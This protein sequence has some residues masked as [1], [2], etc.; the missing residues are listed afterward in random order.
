MISCPNCGRSNPEDARFCLNCGHALVTR[1]GAEERRRVTA[2]FADLV[3]STALSDRHDPEVV[4][5]VVSEFFERATTEIRRYGGTAEQFRGDAVM[6]VFGLHQAH[7][8]DPERAVRAAFAVRGAL[9]DLAP[10]AA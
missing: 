10:A 6:A 9:A 5:A 2:L 4:R 7:E 1:V 3:S 8:D